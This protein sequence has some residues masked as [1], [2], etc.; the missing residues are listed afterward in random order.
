MVITA[1]RDIDARP[2]LVT[3]TETLTWRRLY[4]VFTYI[5]SLP[6]EKDICDFRN[7]SVKLPCVYL[8][9]SSFLWQEFRLP[10]PIFVLSVPL[11][12]SF[13]H[14]WI[15]EILKTGMEEEMLDKTLP[16]A[17]KY[18]LMQ[19]IFYSLAVKKMTIRRIEVT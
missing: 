5:Y 12:F 3:L 13:P 10:I 14:V 16:Q 6:I 1:P 18:H 11:Y 8:C 19:V 4:C 17:Y 7:V 9:L 15:M 2:I